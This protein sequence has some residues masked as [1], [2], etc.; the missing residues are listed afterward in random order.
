M[1]SLSFLSLALFT[2]GVLLFCARKEKTPGDFGHFLPLYFSLLLIF[3]FTL[4]TPD[5]GVLPPP[6]L[7]D[8]SLSVG[9]NANFIPLH[10]IIRFLPY[11]SLFARNILGNIILFI[12]FGASLRIKKGS[13]S[14]IKTLLCGLFLSFTIETLQFFL[15]DRCFDVDDILLNTLGTAIGWLCASAFKILFRRRQIQDGNT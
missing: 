11:K 14:I 2:A 3:R 15:P 1:F 10:T 13:A 5:G 8:C 9:R 4:F 6:A 7:F 12:P